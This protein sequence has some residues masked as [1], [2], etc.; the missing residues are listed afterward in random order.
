MKK[1]NFKDTVGVSE[2]KRTG[3]TKAVE[4][5]EP[6]RSELTSCQWLYFGI[7]FQFW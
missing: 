1:E 5:E 2:A 6:L 7:I 4:K 3:E